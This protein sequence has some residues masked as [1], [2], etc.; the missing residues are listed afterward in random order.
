[1][2]TG[3]DIDEAFGRTKGTVKA[4]YLTDRLGSTLALSDANANS[5]TTYSY[6]PY[7]KA[8]VSGLADDNARAFTGREDDGTGLLYYRARYYDPAAGRFLSEDQIDISSDVNLYRYVRN[9]PV[10]RVDPDGRQAI[11]LPIPICVA[12]PLLCV[13]IAVVGVCLAGGIAGTIARD[14]DKHKRCS[15]QHDDDGTSGGVSCEALRKSGQCTGPYPGTDLSSQKA[16]QD[17]AR[18]AAP[19]ACR[20][21]L[22][23]CGLVSF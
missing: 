3:L 14:R 15:C 18:A 10:N 9:D 1:M 8:T 6:E 12:Y 21:C 20:G 17:S 7:G 11:P 16:C 22:V 19:A 13:G 23:H 5:S 2:I 4:E